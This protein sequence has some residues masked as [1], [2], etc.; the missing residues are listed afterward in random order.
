MQVINSN[1]LL[2]HSVAMADSHAIVIQGVVVHGDTEWRTNSILTTVAF[3]N[4][5]LLVVVSVARGAW[6]RW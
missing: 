1:A 6:G 4:R 2:R 3:A 5:I